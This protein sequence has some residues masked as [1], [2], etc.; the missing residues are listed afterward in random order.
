MPDALLHPLPPGPRPAQPLP[1][2][3]DW[4]FELIDQYHEVIRD[5]ARRFGLEIG[6]AH[7]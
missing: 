2:P 5:T 6:R 1:A 7:V 4:S 3:S